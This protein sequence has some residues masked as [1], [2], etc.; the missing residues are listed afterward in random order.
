MEKKYVSKKDVKRIASD[1]LQ[2][3]RTKTEILAEL[4]DVYYE[5]DLLA[6]FIAGTPHPETKNKL[7]LVNIL[8][9]IISIVIVAFRFLVFGI[10]YIGSGLTILTL[11]MG[12]SIFTF[13]ATS[14]RLLS[15][16]CIMTFVRYFMNYGISQYLL[17]DL[18]LT[19]VIAVLGFYLGSKLFPNYGILAVKKDSH[20]APILE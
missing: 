3:G 16:V 11:I 2:K 6:K 20:G 19:L 8:L 12:I 15:I 18:G 4:T 9:A 1:E 14:Y 17:V 5:K 10:D 7:K 13:E